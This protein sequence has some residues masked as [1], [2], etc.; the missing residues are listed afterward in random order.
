MVGAGTWNGA[1]LNG[2]PQVKVKFSVEQFLATAPLWIRRQY[3]EQYSS[4]SSSSQ[5]SF[6]TCL[7]LLSLQVK[8]VIAESGWRTPCLNSRLDTQRSQQREAGHLF[9]ELWIIMDS[10]Q[11]PSGCSCLMPLLAHLPLCVSGQLTIEV[12]TLAFNP[13]PSLCIMWVH[14]L[15]YE[16]FPFVPEALVNFNHL[17]CPSLVFAGFYTWWCLFD[18]PEFS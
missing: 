9:M 12:Q 10:S 2:C 14:Y 5:T 7:G 16:S 18:A 17:S 4:L 8:L 15:C 1:M 6:W 11:H 3:P 13:F